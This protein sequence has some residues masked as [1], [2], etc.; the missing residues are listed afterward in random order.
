MIK[1]KTIFISNN[2]SEYVESSIV[3]KSLIL[4]VSGNMLIR[5]KS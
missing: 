3:K 5:W 4:Y 2:K 1:N